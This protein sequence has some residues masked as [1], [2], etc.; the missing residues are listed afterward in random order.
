M[1]EFLS[2]VSLECNSQVIDDW[3]T[4]EEDARVLRKAVN[5]AKKTGVMS[6]T[7]R[8]GFT[9]GYAV[10]KN[11]PE[12]DFD[13]VQDGTFTV[14]YENGRRVT[15]TGCSVV[16]VGALKFDGDKEAI[17]DIKF[18]ASARVEG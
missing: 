1:D 17:K 12:F 18:I 5:L 9:V 4:F 8:H 11:K 15:F 10:P 14:D 2:T 13:S 3:S 7:Q 16:E 6:V